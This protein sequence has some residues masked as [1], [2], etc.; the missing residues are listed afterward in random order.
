[1]R[2]L[3][4]IALLALTGCASS[5]PP[6]PKQPDAPT[7]PSVVA[8][9]TK[10]W[11]TADAKV[12]AAI[13]IA[14]ENA[15]RPEVV[16]SETAVALSFLPAPEAG[17]LAIARAR[18]AKA[19]QKDY[20]AAEAFGKKLLSQIDTSWLK[21]QAD[22]TEAARVS[23]LK[24]ARIV[25]LTKA[26]EQAKKDAAANLWSLAGIAVAVIGAVAM[27]FAGPRIGISLLASSAAIGA[28]PFIV[29]S[30]YFGIIVGTSLAL[31]AC[32]GLYWLWDRVRDSAN[33][34]D[35]PKV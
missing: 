31:A 10:Q 9:V 19:D 35:E 11:D 22:T 28:F 27:V 13:S 29:E 30:E 32:L 3:L 21:V 4:V 12:S 24:D 26:V 1:V 5:P 17:E 20:A 23:Q 8:T 16:R 33:K 18:A 7:S 6:L 25:E 15:D 14:K 2:S 34:S